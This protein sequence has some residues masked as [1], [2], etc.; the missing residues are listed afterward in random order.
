MTVDYNKWGIVTGIVGLV[1]L[2]ALPIN[3]ILSTTFFE[4]VFSLLIIIGLF[5]V[6]LSIP[7]GLATLIQG[8]LSIKKGNR[9]KT[10]LV[11]GILYVLLSIPLITITIIALTTEDISGNDP[12]VQETLEAACNEDYDDCLYNNDES[13]C[14]EKKG[15]CLSSF[16]K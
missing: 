1:L 3:Y 6:F 11:L 16:P 14:S 12:S 13:V 2:I 5:S 7:F 15:E 9:K 8:I 4:P 10:A